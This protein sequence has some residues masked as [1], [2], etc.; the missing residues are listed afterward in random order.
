MEFWN[1]IVET[2]TPLGTAGSVILIILALSQLI[3]QIIE[4]CGK[5]SPVFLKVFKWLWQKHKEKIQKREA[6]EQ[7]V[8]DVRTLL[9]NVN[10]H[11]SEDN[12]KK[13][14]GWMQSVNTDLTWMH[15]R[16]V[17]YDASIER[18][19]TEMNNMSTTLVAASE[20][21]EKLR[22]QNEEDHAQRIRN[23]IIEFAGKISRPDYQATKDEF[24]YIFRIY[25]EYEE[26]IKAHRITNDQINTCIE[27]IREEYSDYLRNNRFLEAK[28]SLS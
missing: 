10:Q 22:K 25:D 4:W 28:R 6:A 16:A 17:V 26:Y 11:Y 24:N 18:L 14:D 15:E 8:V 23:K 5:T 9:D 3:G 12:I 27:V 19:T 21:L 1:Q 7:T 20:Q 13:R 2:L